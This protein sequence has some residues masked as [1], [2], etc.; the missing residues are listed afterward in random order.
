MSEIG[1]NFI[2]EVNQGLDHPIVSPWLVAAESKSTE[3]SAASVSNW[4]QYDT[5]GKAV[6]A[7]KLSLIS[8]GFL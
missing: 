2:Q 3:D 6:E 4:V 5:D 1:A 8:A 7:A